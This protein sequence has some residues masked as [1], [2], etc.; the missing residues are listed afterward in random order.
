MLLGKTYPFYLV[1]ENSLCEDWVTERL[2]DAF[3]EKMI[4]IVMNWANMNQIAPKH[5]YIDVRDF[6]TIIGGIKL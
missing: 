3:R 4:P 6:S 5:S 2:F 1:F